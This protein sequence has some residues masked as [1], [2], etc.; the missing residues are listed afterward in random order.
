MDPDECPTT[1]PTVLRIRNENANYRRAST[2]RHSMGGSSGGSP[3][4]SGRRT[5]L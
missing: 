5:S 4:G 1:N 2:H 3:G